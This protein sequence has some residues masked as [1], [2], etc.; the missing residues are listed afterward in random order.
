MS[1]PVKA[2]ARHVQ[3]H[4]ASFATTMIHERHSDRWQS[5]LFDGARHRIALA[6]S[7]ERIDEALAA[8]RNE[9]DDDRFS[10]S[11][12]LIAEIRVANIDRSDSN[13]LVTLDALTIEAESAC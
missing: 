7:G 1:D 11:G 4:C 5:L 6:I 10:I 12:H 3:R 9:I 2:I 13:A 8:I